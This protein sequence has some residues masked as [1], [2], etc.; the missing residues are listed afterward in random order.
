MTLN[1]SIGLHYFLKQLPSSFMLYYSLTKD[2]IRKCILQF[3]DVYIVK[4]MGLLVLMTAA[5]RIFIIYFFISLHFYVHFLNSSL[6]LIVF[7]N[8]L[9]KKIRRI[10]K[11][12]SSKTKSSC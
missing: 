3:I 10:D 8:L 1:F 11:L 9:H 2:H 12:K 4:T 5:T 7:F 6:F